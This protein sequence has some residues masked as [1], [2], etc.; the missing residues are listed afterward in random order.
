MARTAPRMLSVVQT[1]QLTPNMIRVT[2]GGEALQ[3]FPPGRESGYIKLHFPP[4]K[5]RI[6]PL[7]GRSKPR[8]RTYTIRAFDPESRQMT[9]DF[10]AHGDNGPASAWAQRARVGNTIAT[11]GMG[12]KK[13]VDMDADW[14]FITGDMTAL[15]AI[16]VNLEQM[17]RDAR[18]YAVIEIMHADDEQALDAP[19]GVELHWVVNPNPDQPN[20]LLADTVMALPWQQGNVNVWVATEFSTMRRLRRYFK[21]QRGVERGDI[22]ASSYWKMGDTDEGNK[23]ARQQ[24]KHDDA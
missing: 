2:F 17:P 19:A 23:R 16:S 13:L 15:P 20:S 9:I 12:A 8:L 10:V 21:Q 4:E 18:G 7:P 5:R 1:Q 22:Y 24:D 3:D 11:T 14:F 6:L